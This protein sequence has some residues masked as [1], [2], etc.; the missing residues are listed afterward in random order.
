MTWLHLVSY[1]AL[2]SFV[3]AAFARA[4]RIA[5]LPL[6]LRWELYP[7]AHEKKRARYGGSYFEELDWWTKP[8]ESSLLGE[9]KVMIPEILLLHG[10]REKNVPHWL[11]TFPFHFGLYLIVT[12][13]V[14]LVAGGIALAA[15]APVGTGSASTGS[16]GLAAL[17]AAATIG[18]GYAGFGLAFLGASALLVR[19]LLEEDYR[20]YSKGSDYF[21]LALFTGAC[22]FALLAQIVADPDFSRMQ[23]FFATLA[24]FGSFQPASGLSPLLAVEAVLFS[25]IVAYVPLTHMSHF[26]TKFFMWHDIRW[27]D[28][29]LARGGKL[30]RQVQ[31]A[32]QYKPTWSAPHIRGNGRKTWVDIA[33]ST[34]IEESKKEIETP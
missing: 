18:L 27:S 3:V 34:G 28:E 12:T 20:E 32:L 33:T 14:L 24:S 19:R 17:L 6:H 5:S 25:L 7:V 11:R 22:G 9:L 1:L 21:N 13:T 26:F 23:A 10:V 16:G 31:E 4:L 8:R 29:P 15:G 30:E 2:V